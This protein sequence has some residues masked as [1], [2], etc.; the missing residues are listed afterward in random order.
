MELMAFLAANTAQP[1][2]VEN[3]KDVTI[4]I[5][6]GVTFTLDT[7]VITNGVLS[8][9]F[10]TR[11]AEQHRKNIDGD[12]T[13]K[14]FAGLVSTKP[15]HFPS[16][17]ASMFHAVPGDGVLKYT[18]PSH[19]ENHTAWPVPD[20]DTIHMCAPAW[21]MQAGG[22]YPEACGETIR[23]FMDHAIL[24][25][26]GWSILTGTKLLQRI[27]APPG[28]QP[29]TEYMRMKFAVRGGVS[30][31]CAD[32]VQRLSV[33]YPFTS[34][35]TTLAFVPEGTSLSVRGHCCSPAAAQEALKQRDLRVWNATQTIDAAASPM[36][37]PAAVGTIPMP[38]GG[39]PA[40]GPP[41][42]VRDLPSDTAVLV[43]QVPS[44]EPPTIER[45]VAAAPSA[46]S[47][48]THE[49]DLAD[50]DAEIQKV[51]AL[52]LHGAAAVNALWLVIANQII[53]VT[54]LAGLKAR[55]SAESRRDAQ[56]SALTK[57]LIL[58]MEAGISNAVVVNA[59]PHD[60]TGEQ[61]SLW[62]Q[63][64]DVALLHYNSSHDRPVSDPWPELSVSP[65]IC[66]ADRVASL[67][68]D[69]TAPRLSR[70][71]E[72]KATIHHQ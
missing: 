23:A 11:F 64:M 45:L 4:V 5:Y 25:T 61:R 31:A 47:V 27:A 40:L 21:C 54:T 14:F 55:F 28:R 10:A 20:G 9:T 6:D 67:L 42:L 70:C 30:P 2:R 19:K 53:A 12:S 69:G 18:P 56:I 1:A 13:M 51:I 16:Y 7:V 38:V 37:L 50:F 59:I 24:G 72:G 63:W 66:E 43:Q 58:L 32:M 34:V 29:W 3:A 57:H 33:L 62:T 39:A 36:L 44:L 48:P 65:S 60:A 35:D 17:A 15:E 52:D 49:M 68:R 71:D 8:I 26:G 41:T 46:V 22:K